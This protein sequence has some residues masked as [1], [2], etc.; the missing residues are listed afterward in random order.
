M[1]AVAYPKCY[2]V[3]RKRVVREW[4]FLSIGAYPVYR[5]V[6]DCFAAINKTQFLRSDST[7]V[8]HIL[9]YVADGDMTLNTV[10][11]WRIIEIFQIT[12]GDVTYGSH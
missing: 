4:Q 11:T 1:S 7:N 12:E 2:R 8:Q 5:T 6:L 10:M 3:C 9:V